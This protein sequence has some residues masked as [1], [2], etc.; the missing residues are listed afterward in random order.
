MALRL[1]VFPIVDV[2]DGR[3]I[4]VHRFVGGALNALLMRAEVA[5]HFGPIG[6]RR[7]EDVLEILVG[8]WGGVRIGGRRQ[9]EDDRNGNMFSGSV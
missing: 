4:K 8:L 9:K 7:A 6:F 3:P 2:F 1:S 5:R